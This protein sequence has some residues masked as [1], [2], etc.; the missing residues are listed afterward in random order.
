MFKII[1][2]SLVFL[3]ITVL[4]NPF[5]HTFADVTG[6][7]DLGDDNLWNT[8]DDALLAQT[9]PTDASQNSNSGSGSTEPQ[10]IASLNP[11]VIPLNLSNFERPQSNL[12]SSGLDLSQFSPIQ[13]LIDSSNDMQDETSDADSDPLMNC[14][15]GRD[16]LANN[17][18]KACPASATTDRPTMFYP[19]PDTRSSNDDDEDPCSHES[20]TAVMMT[21][22][23]SC[24][25]P[26]V[27]EYRTFTPHVFNCVEG[28]ICHDI[29]SSLF[30][31][32]AWQEREITS[33]N[34]LFSRK[35]GV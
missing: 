10:T 26:T 4:A 27:S 13:K 22:H 23:V 35:S 28:K 5:S 11:Q 32:N 3:S 1:L 29:Y 17:P 16:N 2:C 34:A 15:S 24:G 18:N 30:I 14:I 21:K 31:D 12:L 8:D 19:S 25:G 6:K 20:F 33:G 9:F 7:S